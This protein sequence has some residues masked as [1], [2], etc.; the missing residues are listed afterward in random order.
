MQYFGLNFFDDTNTDKKVTNNSIME[1]LN[2]INYKLNN[3]GDVHYNNII[4]KLQGIKYNQ[5]RE[6]ALYDST[7]ISIKLSIILITVIITLILVLIII[8]ILKII[9][10]VFKLL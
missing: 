8:S 2:S 5:L 7:D 1:E 4:K 10:N 3:E 9:L 6:K